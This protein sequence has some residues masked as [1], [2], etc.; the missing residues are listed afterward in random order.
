ML[1]PENLEKGQ[2]V[3]VGQVG[4]VSDEL[5]H[6]N[7]RLDRLYVQEVHAAKEAEE[8]LAVR[9]CPRRQ[10]KG[11]IIALSEK[12]RVLHAPVLVSVIEQREA[13]LYE[14]V[15]TSQRVLMPQKRH[16]SVPI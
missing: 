16:F 4:R 6:V 10:H 8:L 12:F 5:Y 3:E 14:V 13:C 15:R 7:G 11:T 9:L 2:V 1:I